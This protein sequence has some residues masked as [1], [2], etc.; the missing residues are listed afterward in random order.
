MG[1][2]ALLGALAVGGGALKAIGSIQEGNAAGNAADFNAR[3]SEQQAAQERDAAAA[4]GRDYRRQEGRRRAS[5]LAARGASGTTGA[6]SPLLVDEATVREIALGASRIKYG[7]DV[8]ATRLQQEAELY[9]MRGRSSRTA[10]Y[11]N[12]GTSLLSGAS[13]WAG[14]YA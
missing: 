6:G 4:E 8:K 7:G 14:Q 12:A 3:A 2:E 9:R 13:S 11:L 1:I 10:G 5:S